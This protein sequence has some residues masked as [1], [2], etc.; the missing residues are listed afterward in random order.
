M[1]EVPAGLPGRDLG[2][3]FDAVVV[4][5]GA[6]LAHPK[7]AVLVIC[8]DV[9]MLVL[10]REQVVGLLGLEVVVPLDSDAVQALEVHDKGSEAR[11]EVGGCVGTVGVVGV[12]GLVDGLLEPVSDLVEG[13]GLHSVSDVVVEGG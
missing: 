7:P 9:G 13:G 11:L 4:A 2:D 5:L 10:P 3:V 8:G 12:G 6:E 1:G